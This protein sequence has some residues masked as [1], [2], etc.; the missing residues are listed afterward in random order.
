[1]GASPVSDFEI[2]RPTGVHDWVFRRGARVLFRIGQISC[3]TPPIVPLFKSTGK[4]GVQATS[5]GSLTEWTCILIVS[6]ATFWVYVFW[7]TVLR[8]SILATT[9]SWVWTLQRNRCLKQINMIG[10]KQQR[11]LTRSCYFE[12]VAMWTLLLQQFS[13]VIIFHY[14]SK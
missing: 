1:M 2:E 12:L 14:F 8:V 4:P 11:P 10:Y 5:Q 7:N 3:S 6:N 9:L 13:G